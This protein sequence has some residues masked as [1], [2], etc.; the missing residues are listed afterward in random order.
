M[1]SISEAKP[2][3]KPNG[4]IQMAEKAKQN[5]H[6]A[7]PIAIVAGL[8]LGSIVDM[9]FLRATILPI[10][11]L[12]VYPMMVSLPVKKLMAPGGG[13]VLGASVGIN[14]VVIPL[15]AYGFGRVF[16]PNDEF[17][18]LGL[19]LMGVLPTSGMTIAWTGMAKG[20]KT[21]AIRMTV[22]GLLL[23]AAFTPLFT[24][25]LLGSKIELPLAKIS[26]QILIIVILPLILG[27]AT[28]RGLI[29]QYGEKKFQNEIK[30]KISLISSLGVLLMVFVAMVL[31]SKKI[32][33]DPGQIAKMI[34]ILLL[35]YLTIYLVSS[36]IGRLAFSK[37]D[38]IALVFGTAMRNLAIVLALAVTL[39]KEDGSEMALLLSLAFVV[40]IQSAVLYTK[41]ADRILTR[42][43]SVS[44]RVQ[45]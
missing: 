33:S 21:A 6:I 3:A 2:S 36:G 7:V 45:A 15:I 18:Q 4:A 9:P 43:S 11:F 20:N 1:Q 24:S 32:L 25:V 39:F 8:V 28:Q 31:K 22:V 41:V 29:Y 42:S 12:M 19:L 5:L 17:L 38:A 37:G 44:P 23:G 10:T 34:P 35:F 40:Q 16:F 14:F 27:Y 13:P 26:S 30:E